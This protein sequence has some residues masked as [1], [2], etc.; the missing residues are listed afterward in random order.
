MKILWMSELET[1]FGIH[2]YMDREYHPS[3]GNIQISLVSP[4]IAYQITRGIEQGTLH[5][6][7][8]ALIILPPSNFGI[9]DSMKATGIKTEVK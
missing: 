3:D 2:A 7:P 1:A 9:N 5:I 8:I 6:T 4:M